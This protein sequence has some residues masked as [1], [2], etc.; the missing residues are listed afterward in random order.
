[1]DVLASSAFRTIS[2][3]PGT[4]AVASDGPPTSTSGVSKVQDSAESDRRIEARKDKQLASGLEALKLSDSAP[5]SKAP[6][7]AG[8]DLAGRPAKFAVD[9]NMGTYDV[10]EVQICQMG[11]W[12]A[13]GEY[14]CVGKISLLG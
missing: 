14:I 1:M 4:D 9:V 2:L 3:Q 10:N 11:S 6:H 8:S 5:S 13:E 12:G 7:A